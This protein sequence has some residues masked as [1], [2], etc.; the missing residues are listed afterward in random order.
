MIHVCIC[1]YKKLNHIGTV[2][3][4][5]YYMQVVRNFFSPQLDGLTLSFFTHTQTAN[6]NDNFGWFGKM[7][8]YIE[9]SNKFVQ[10]QNKYWTFSGND[11]LNM[12]VLIIKHNRQSTLID[13]S[14]LKLLFTSSNF[15][16]RKILRKFSTF[17]YN[18]YLFVARIS[19]RDAMT[20]LWM[21]LVA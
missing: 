16:Y 7:L 18:L 11:W 19:T 12:N 20:K 9:N 13:S 8:R 14:L 15:S 6:D 2:H 21:C 4:A 10:S 3:A 5:Q 17:V 1:T